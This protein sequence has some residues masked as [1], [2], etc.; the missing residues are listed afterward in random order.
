MFQK[1][2]VFLRGINVN[3]ITIKM[4][5]LKSAFEE[6]GFS[7]VKTLLATGNVVISSPGNG[8]SKEELTAF[9]EGKLREHFSY[10]AHVFL[11]DSAETTT[12]CAAANEITVSES[13]HHYFLLCGDEEILSEIGALFESVSHGPEEQ[14]ILLPYGASWIVPKGSTL[15]SEFGSK[16]LGRKKY[17]DKLTSRNMNTMEKIR[18]LMQ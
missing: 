4:E 15:S 17:K 13:C 2:A 5:A 16:V 6:M 11:L 9:I 14:F 18:A 12:V 10:D 3:G 1:Y 8:M 7:D